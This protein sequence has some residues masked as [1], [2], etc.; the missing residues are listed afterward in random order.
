MLRE[1][2]QNTL[3]Q[4]DRY[5]RIRRGIT[6]PL[7]RTGYAAIGGNA[8]HIQT[9]ILSGW[10]IGNA[11][12]LSPRERLFCMVANAMLPDRGRAAEGRGKV[13]SS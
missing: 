12:R 3:L 11:L 9:H 4:R 13:A 1:R 5:S 10:V 7:K 2:S 8:M 6:G